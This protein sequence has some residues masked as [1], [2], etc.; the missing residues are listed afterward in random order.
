MDRF[1]AAALTL[2]D[3]DVEIPIRP[4][5]ATAGNPIACR[6]WDIGAPDIR[7]TSTP[8]AGADGVDEGGGYLGAR[9]VILDLLIRGD[10]AGVTAGHDPYWYVEK[11]AAMC[12]PSRRPQLKITRASETAGGTSWYLGLRGNPWTLTYE[13]VS[14]AM[15]TMQLT[16]TAPLG[17]LESEL[18]TI[19]SR[20]ANPADATDWHFPA[21]F[22]HGFG[23]AT[24]NPFLT[25]NVAGSAP[26]NPIVY[27]TGPMTDPQVRDDKGNKFRFTGL[28]LAAGET[29]QINMGAGTVLKADPE[30]GETNP[31]T[32]AF[33]YVDF[34]VSTFWQWQPGPH[35]VALLSS[36][37]SFALQWR[38][39][40][41]TI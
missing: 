24:G 39:R 5:P 30:T 15:L 37:G 4:V 36:G 10:G 31:A 3:G 12:H 33:A 27:L 22:P 26:V 9:T 8:R 16:F 13:R 6:S 19:A 1:A 40:Q 21:A 20:T 34:A 11:L 38:D 25:A 14:A 29:V 17:M 7:I 41:L 2:V 28:A 23:A 18:H 32:D 35:K